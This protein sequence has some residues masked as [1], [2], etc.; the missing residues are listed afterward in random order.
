MWWK[1]VTVVSVVSLM[2]FEA[3]CAEKLGGS[4]RL[5]QISEHNTRPGN[6]QISSDVLSP[7]R[8][9]KKISENKT[10]RLRDLFP[11]D[12]SEKLGTST[13]SN[14]LSFEPWMPGRGA[15]GVRFEV[16]W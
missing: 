3:S 9:A 7:T 5:V 4:Y 1:L 10:S 16:T 8:P 12:I 6:R 15:V 2:P 11:K 13:K 14:N